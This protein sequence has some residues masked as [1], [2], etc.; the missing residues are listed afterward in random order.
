MLDRFSVPR[1]RASSRSRNNSSGESSARRE[2][3]AGRFGAR[4]LRQRGAERQTLE[5][6]TLTGRREAEQ[7]SALELIERALQLGD[8]HARALAEGGQVRAAAGSGT[9][10]HQD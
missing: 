5:G 8:A 3:A 1:E 10:K 4:A 7:A 2:R 9:T 6:E